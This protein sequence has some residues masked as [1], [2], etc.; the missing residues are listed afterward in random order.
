MV[1]IFLAIFVAL[2]QFIQVKL[3]L[4]FNQKKNPSVVL[5]KKK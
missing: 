5:E 3:S 4:S 1:G 2:V